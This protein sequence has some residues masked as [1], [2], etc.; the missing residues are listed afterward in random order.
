L[1]SPLKEFHY[2]A[3]IP[4]DHM[5]G[6]EL[7]LQGRLAEGERPPYWAG[8]TPTLRLRDD[9]IVFVTGPLGASLLKWCAFPV[10][11]AIQQAGRP[12]DIVAISRSDR[13]AFVLTLTRAGRLVLA[14]GALL[15]IDL[16][17]GIT[18]S[19]PPDEPMYG[20]AQFT[21]LFNN[22]NSGSS[23]T[24]EETPEQRLPGRIVA[25]DGKVR[26][27][28]NNRDSTILA[29]YD[30]YLEFIES[31]TVWGTSIESISV[32]SVESAEVINAARRSATLVIE[33]FSDR[34]R[35]ESQDGTMLKSTHDI[36]RA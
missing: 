9:K 12:G 33:R 29:G 19:R 35:G 2:V 18:L 26:S 36:D 13:G 7:S 31:Q 3:T 28:L 22:L 25:T 5:R 27:L 16:G 15:G 11:D 24:A 10:G 8:P 34:L 14:V 20:A 6:R 32:T 4:S 17:I 30:I 1:D 21:A 23:T